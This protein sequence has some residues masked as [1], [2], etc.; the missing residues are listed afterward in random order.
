[1][2]WSW[3]KLGG[4]A[5]VMGLVV[6]YSN[7]WGA[8]WK[9]FAVATTGTFQYDTSSVIS[10]SK[11]VVRVWIHNA[12]KH[13]SSLIELNCKDRSYHVLDSV[14]Y[15]EALHMKRRDDY[16]DNPNWLNISRG[17]VPEPLYQIL[18]P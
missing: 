8:D 16:Y 12:T 9:E 14:E 15:D 10:L 5:L 11:D 18:C 17:S 6:C 7:A 1:M 2:K 13:E 4:V 3:S